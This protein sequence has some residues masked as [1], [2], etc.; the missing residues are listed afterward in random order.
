[1]H[2]TTPNT[3]TNTDFYGFGS[4]LTPEER[5]A[6]PNQANVMSEIIFK[7]KLTQEEYEMY[8]R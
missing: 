2:G 5:S 7:V 6:Q 3:N 4:D 1:M 8:L